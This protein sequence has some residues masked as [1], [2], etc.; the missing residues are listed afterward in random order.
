M[1][2]KGIFACGLEYE[3]RRHR[4]FTL[5]LPT[6]ADVE[7]AIEAAQ[8]EAGAN[9]CAARIDRHKW[10]A[11]LSVD[12]IPAEKNERPSAGRSG[13]QGMGHF[14]RRRGRA[15]KKARGCQR[16][17]GG[18]LRRTLRLAQAALVRQGFTLA[19]ARGLTLPEAEAF[20]EIFYPPKAQPAGRRTCVSKRQD[21]RQW[22]KQHG[23]S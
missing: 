12:G 23:R 10:A 17:P 13:R 4:S 20:L 14:E 8:A 15:G 11:C 3:G 7:N 22:K 6:M 2:I 16:G 5:R 19:E 21:W 1:E 18:E 9:A